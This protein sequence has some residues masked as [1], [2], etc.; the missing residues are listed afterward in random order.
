MERT[1]QLLKT[2]V[3]IVVLALKINI[4]FLHQRQKRQTIHIKLN[5]FI[6]ENITALLSFPQSFTNAV[7]D[8]LGTHSKTPRST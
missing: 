4:R 7:P 5:Q 2:K 1:K 8:L 3:K 6:R